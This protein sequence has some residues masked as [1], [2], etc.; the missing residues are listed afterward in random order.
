LKRIAVPP[1]IT[2]KAF[3]KG[4]LPDDRWIADKPVII[5]AVAKRLFS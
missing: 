2:R 1:D 4:K 5:E 3:Y